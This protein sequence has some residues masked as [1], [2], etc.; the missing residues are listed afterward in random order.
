MASRRVQ[1]GSLSET[2]RKVITY[3][4]ADPSN[5]VIAAT[6]SRKD[7]SQPLK[8]N[9]H[10]SSSSSAIDD[11]VDG[12]LDRERPSSASYSRPK[13]S[14]GTSHPS[15]D[16]FFDYVIPSPVSKHGK[17]DLTVSSF[18]NLEKEKSDNNSLRSKTLGEKPLKSGNK[19]KK[20]KKLRSTK[21]PK[22]VEAEEI[23]KPAL[24]PDETIF[25]GCWLFG[26][27]LRV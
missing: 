8:S 27:L 7:H 26:S 1:L 25:I 12:D 2:P 3:N 17:I 22:S 18:L 24:Q 10:W 16:D 14:R 23:E 19:T 4:E 9:L 13:T 21:K 15:P 11:E 6:P 20:S 5:C